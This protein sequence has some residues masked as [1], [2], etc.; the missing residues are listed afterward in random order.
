MATIVYTPMNAFLAAK[1][2]ADY[3]APYVNRIDNLSGNGVNVVS[4]ITQIFLRHNLS[5]K[6]LAASFKN[7]QQIHNVCLAGVH[8]VTTAPELIE[9]MIGQPSIEANVK[10]FK[11]EWL[12]LYGEE[13]MNLISTK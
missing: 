1:A 2:G 12:D 4:E 6:V 9:E 3:V 13:S 11:K 10:Q 8:G 5:C 7:V